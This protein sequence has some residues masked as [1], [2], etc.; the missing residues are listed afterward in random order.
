MALKVLVS[1]TAAACSRGAS[2]A[3]ALLASSGTPGCGFASGSDLLAAAGAGER[4]GTGDSKR[5]GTGDSEGTG[6]G[7]T[8]RSGTGDSERAGAGETERSGTGATARSGGGDARR[9]LSEG[10]LSGFVAGRR[11]EPRTA[12]DSLTTGAGSSLGAA[13]SWET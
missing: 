13:S 1:L 11:S 3:A 12:A 6:A 2:T 4:S 10:K 9:L 8:E 7:E 5:S